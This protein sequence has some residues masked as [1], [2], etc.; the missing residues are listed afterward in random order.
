M[1]ELLQTEQRLLLEE[2]WAVRALSD[3]EVD[4]LGT[5]ASSTSTSPPLDFKALQS[6]LRGK[7]LAYNTEPPSWW[8]TEWCHRCPIKV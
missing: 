3:T 8:T 5:V 7:C 2:E 1:P 4:S 6:L